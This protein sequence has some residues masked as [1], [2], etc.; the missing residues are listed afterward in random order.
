MQT[1]NDAVVIENC[2]RWK[3]VKCVDFEDDPVPRCDVTIAFYHVGTPLRVYK[4]FQLDAYNSQESTI[5][6]RNLD[7]DAVCSEKIQRGL[8]TVL[9][10]YTLIS[11]ANKTVGNRATKLLAVEAACK[12]TLVDVNLAST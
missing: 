3:V 1:L 2:N 9:N 11:T 5:V 10:A 8:R 4:T 7:A 12:G 6:Q